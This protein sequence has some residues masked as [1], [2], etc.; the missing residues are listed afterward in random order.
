M[1]RPVSGVRLRSATAADAAA[2]V[3]IYR[4]FVEDTVVSFERVPPSV[5]VMGERIA[6]ALERWGWLVAEVGD[7][8]AG[9]AYAGAHRARDAYRYSVETSVYVDP[10]YRRSG[11]AL[12]LYSDL[13]ENL[14]ERGYAS[15]YAG[16]TIPNEASVAFHR[17]FGFEPA[18]VFPCVGRKFGVWHDVLWMY[19]PIGRQGAEEVSD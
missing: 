9:Y 13:F 3:E 5:D 16:I 6:V 2:I 18:G 10:N 17:S 11:V 7:R 12:A 4:P 14:R 1:I 15:A 19:R 8:I